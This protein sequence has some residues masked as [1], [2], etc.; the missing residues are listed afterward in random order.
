MIA[1]LRGAL[2]ERGPDGVV[3][4]AGGV[5]Y[6]VTLSAAALRALPPLG[7]N[8]FL[9]IHT[10]VVQDGALQLY[11]F[12][13][14]EERRLFETLLSVQGV[15]P[16]VA[17]AILSSLR[18]GDLVKAISTADLATLTR[19]RGVGRKTAERI[20]VELRDKIG[21]GAGG[22]AAGGEGLPGN[23]PPG[24]IGEVHSALSALGYKPSEFGAILAKLDEKQHVTDLI[25][26]ALALLRIK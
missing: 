18:I 26:Q 12:A 21:L 15:G 8:A 24:R 5:G 22:A 10:H 17:L 11:G 9:L 16:K 3:I 7:A 1:S 6:A 13:D 14:P 4:E 19:I 2:L 20:T 25:K 23:I